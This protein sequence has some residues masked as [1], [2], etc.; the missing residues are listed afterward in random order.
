[1]PSEVKGR[2]VELSTLGTGSTTGDEVR[3]DEPQR[4]TYW[5][6]DEEHGNGWPVWIDLHSHSHEPQN[7]V[8]KKGVSGVWRPRGY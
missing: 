6:C 2:L 8:P 3:D 5:L 1:M 7:W 4:L